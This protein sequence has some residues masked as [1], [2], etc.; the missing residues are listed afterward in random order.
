MRLP[1]ELGLSHYDDPPP[2]RFDDLETLRAADRFRFANRLEAWID[3]EDGKVVRAGYSGSG[4]IGATTLRMGESAVTI[5]AVP[6]PDIQHEPAVQGSRAVFRQ[7]AGGRTGAPMPR[8]VNRPPYVQITAPTAWTTLELTIEAD[9]TSSFEVIGASPFPRHWIYDPENSLSQKSGTTDYTTWSR[10]SFGDQ[11]PWGDV[12]SPAMVTEV[13]TALE[14]EL[15]L[16]IMR[17][18]D[19]PDVRRL[20]IG[21]V[22]TR[23]GDQGDDLFLVLDGVLTVE[24]DGNDLAEIGPGA[25]VGERSALEGG[26]RTSTLTAVT[27]VKVAVASHDSL[28][29][30]KLQTL[31][32]DRRREDRIM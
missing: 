21:D 15:S 6:F 27:P 3:V 23:Q 7:T 19:S 20:D 2:D 11:T 14:R 24:V 22:L 12:D 32:A 1:M 28:D 4:L 5:P 30:D 29:P 26:V 13:E 9:G 10:E 18:G 25:V 31:A 8:R 16:K 17:D